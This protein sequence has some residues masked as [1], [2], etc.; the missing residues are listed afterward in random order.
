MTTLT[1]VEP[2][3]PNDLHFALCDLDDVVTEA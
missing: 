1:P 2:P 3:V